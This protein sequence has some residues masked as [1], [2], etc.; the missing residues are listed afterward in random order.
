MDG[1]ANAAEFGGDVLLQ[2]YNDGAEL[3]V[4]DGLI[5]PDTGYGTAV[6][7]SLLG[8][9]IEDPGKVETRLGWWGDLLADDEAPAKMVSRFQYATDGNPLTPMSMKGVAEAAKLDLA[10]LIDEGAVDS[11]DITASLRDTKGLALRVVLKKEGEDVYDRTYIKG[12]A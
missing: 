7:L 8:G 6:L 11:I 1:N 5:V 3:S 4:E 10:W 2:L 9:N 12:V